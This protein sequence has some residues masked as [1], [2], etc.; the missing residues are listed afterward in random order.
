M[1][2]TLRTHSTSLTLSSYQQPVKSKN[3]VQQEL[4]FSLLLLQFS[5][6]LLHVPVY[7]STNSH[8]SVTG[9]TVLINCVSTIELHLSGLIGT[10][11]HPDMQKIRII[12]VSL[13]MSYNG[14]L[15]F[16]CYYLR[17]VPASK[18]IDDA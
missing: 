4:L 13:K 17:H 8:Y 15:K 3:Y 16:G 6:V 2:P 1:H 11:S 12:G 7:L 5:A 10:A 18:P 14:S 9:N